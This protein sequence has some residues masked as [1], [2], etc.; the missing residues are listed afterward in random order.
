MRFAVRG[1]MVFGPKTPVVPLD[2]HVILISN[3]TQH[4]A[5]SWTRSQ[6]T[7]NTWQKA[8]R[9]NL[10]T[11]DT[12]L[13]V[14]LCPIIFSSVVAQVMPAHLVNLGP[15]TVQG[16]SVWHLRYRFAPTTGGFKG[17]V[18]QTDFY[19]AQSSLHW[20][21]FTSLY[22]SADFTQRVVTDY[23]RVN[24]PVTITAPTVGSSLP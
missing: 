3:D 5:K 7:H 17:T 6:A 2:F 18:M 11:H 21:R 10:P 14:Y 19:L 9:V 13:T 23:S 4:T 8:T 24:A 12:D 15:A 20:L 16:R 1:T 22:G